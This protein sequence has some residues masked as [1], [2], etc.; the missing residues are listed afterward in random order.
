MKV[1]KKVAKEPFEVYVDD[2]G[3]WR[4]PPERDETNNNGKWLLVKTGD[5]IPVG[6]SH[7]LELHNPDW[8]KTIEV[9]YEVETKK[10]EVKVEAKEVIVEEVKEP[11][12]ITED[13]NIDITSMNK[14]ELEAYA[15]KNFGV[16]IDK[17]KSL[18]NLIVQV[19]ELVK[20]G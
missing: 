11:V 12:E 3:Y 2:N 14:D 9:D 1:F 7:H 15:R 16:D 5:E 10:K 8:V 20:N 18:K 6:V 4:R 19:E 13:L 17:R